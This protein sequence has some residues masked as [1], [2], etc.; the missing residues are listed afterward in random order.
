MNRIKMIREENKDGGEIIEINNRAVSIKSLNFEKS[1]LLESLKIMP[2]IGKN[3]EHFF[4]SLNLLKELNKLAVEQQILINELSQVPR[5]KPIY[6]QEY[7][8]FYIKKILSNNQSIEK[9]IQKLFDKIKDKIPEDFF[10]KKDSIKIVSKIYQDT[11]FTDNRWF[12]VI[13]RELVRYVITEKFNLKNYHY[14]L[15][16]NK[17]IYGNE[18]TPFEMDVILIMDDNLVVFE[19]KTGQFTRK[20]F[21]YF[22]GEVKN[23]DADKGIIILYDFFGDTTF[24]VKKYKNKGI[25]LFDKFGLKKFDTAVGM[26]EKNFKDLF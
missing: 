11:F 12:E 7:E 22:S 24:N 10:E 21:L 13:I 9:L 23:I 2:I 16:V 20:E 5:E 19:C 17:N 26:I 14:K 3:I 8:K 1:S 18:N 4:N 25:F 15:Y 6:R